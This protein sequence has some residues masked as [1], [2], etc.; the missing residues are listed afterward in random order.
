MASRAELVQICIELGLDWRNKSI[1]EMSEMIKVEADKRFK[2]DRD[3]SVH[4]I[5]DALL[6]FLVKEYVYVIKDREDNIV[7]VDDFIMKRRG[8]H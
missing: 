2:K 1:V 6:V 7:D 4:T 5:S 3:I 8:E